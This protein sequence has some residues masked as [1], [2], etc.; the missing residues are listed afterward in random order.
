MKITFDIDC[1]PAEARAFLG[2]PD[3]TPLHDAWLARAQALMTEGITPAD[4]DRMTRAWTGG[5]PG[6]S[7]GL[8]KM[9]Q[10]FW[11]AAGMGKKDGGK[12]D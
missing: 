9:Q 3:V 1:T 12:K 11:S 6:M 5:L 4:I 8:E 10:L 2:L 7:E